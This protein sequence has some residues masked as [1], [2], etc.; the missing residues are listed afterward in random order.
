MEKLTVTI[1]DNGKQTFRNQKGEFH[2][3]VGPAAV[4]SD[5]TEEYWVN[6]KLHRE[7]GPAVVY[8]NGIESYYLNGKRHREDGPAIVYPSGTEEYYYLNGK[9]HREDGPA[10]VYP[11]GIESYYLN[12]KSLS[13]EEWEEQVKEVKEVTMEELHNILGYP[14]KIKE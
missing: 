7:D 1:Y 12:G 3:P 2:N 14:V 11:N 6:G 13:K 4:Y 8:P 9:L 5:G 10:I